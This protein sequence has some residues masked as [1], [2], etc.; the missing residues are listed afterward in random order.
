MNDLSTAYAYVCV[1]VHNEM[2]FKLN[3]EMRPYLKTE[4]IMQNKI[5]QSWTALFYFYDISK[6]VN[7]MKTE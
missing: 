1:C 3:M 2:P 6:V 5:T 7:L 4:A